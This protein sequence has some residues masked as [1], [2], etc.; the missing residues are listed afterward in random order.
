MRLS[1]LEASLFKQ[2]PEGWTFDS[3]YPRIFGRRRWTYLL[4]DAQKERLTEGLRRWVR[5]AALTTIGFAILLAIPLAFRFSDFLRSLLAGS[6]RAWLLLCL[7]LMLVWGTLATAV[8]IAK[9]RWFHPVLRDARRIGP[10]GPLSALRL[11]A[12]STAVGE[13][14]RRIIMITLALLACVLYLSMFS[15]DAELLLAMAVLFGLLDVW[16]M[17]V[18]VSKLRVQRSA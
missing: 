9:K 18:L 4:T 3:T 13:L 7:V 5:T 17:G 11:M 15:L 1:A 14:R 16:Y 10:A 8:F 6:P 2:T 12:E